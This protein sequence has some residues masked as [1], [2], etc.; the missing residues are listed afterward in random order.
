MDDGL[1]LWARCPVHEQPNAGTTCRLCRISL[2][3]NARQADRL[4]RR[5]GPDPHQ[6]PAWVLP[7]GAVA[8]DA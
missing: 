5:F 4:T 7:A 6:W 8:A 2:D 1:I 3:L